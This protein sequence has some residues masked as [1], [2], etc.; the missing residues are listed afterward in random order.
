MALA[1]I[2]DGADHSG[3]VVQL[4]GADLQPFG[5]GRHHGGSHLGRNGVDEQL[6]LGAHA[7]ADQDQ[8]GVEDVH[9]AGKALRDLVRPVVQQGKDGLVACLRSGEDRAAIRPGGVFLLRSTDECGGGGVALP[10]AR[11]PAGARH[12]VERVEPVVAQLTAQTAGTFQQTAPGQDAAAD[13]GAQRHPDDVG[14]TLCAAD[15]DFAQAH[16]VGVVRYG[17]GQAEQRFKFCFD[18]GADVVGQIAAGADDRSGAA[19][20]LAGGRNAHADKGGRG[21][22]LRF[23]KG[24]GC[25]AHRGQDG[26]LVAVKADALLGFGQHGTGLIHDAQLDGGAADINGKILFCL[27]KNVSASVVHGVDGTGETGRD[28]S[29]AG[30]GTADHEGERTGFQ[31]LDGLF[32]IVDVPLGDDLGR[33]LGGQL[34]DEGEVDVVDALRL[35]GVAAHRGAHKVSTSFGAGHGI[36]KV[37]AV[38]HQ[39]LVGILC[40]DGADEF[41]RGGAVRAERTGALHGEDVHTAG[42]QL[43]HFLHGHGDVHRGAGVVLFDDADDGQVHDSLDLGD[44]AHGV[45]ADADGPAHGGGFG[46]QGHHAALL[47]VQR[48]VLQR[49]AGDDQ[50]ALDL[51]KQFFL[52]HGIYPPF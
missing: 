43:V 33:A 51:S 4:G 29:G 7:A 36:F 30:D 19:V 24:F 48:L 2:V 26:R 35:R 46:H 6:L 42:H 16:A 14:V 52:I 18:G 12:T 1:E 34:V 28:L 21:E 11:S 27:H 41:R 45:G 15:P 39:Q 38:G 5:K 47:G 50:A 23:Y 44:V 17:H 8:L 9:H 13:A 37:V 22:A 20:D 3:V 40:L 31:C 25:L 32:G 10:A 49:L